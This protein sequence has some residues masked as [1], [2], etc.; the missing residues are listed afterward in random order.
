MP[1]AKVRN[2]DLALMSACDGVITSLGTFGWWAGHFSFQ[3][4]G[5][6]IY[7][8]NTFNVS[9]VRKIGEVAKVDNFFPPEWIG[10]EAPALD[11]Q[12]N[13]VQNI[14]RDVIKNQPG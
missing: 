3:N 7:F 14:K 4:G 9:Q 8:K 13:M 1:Q 2:H 12:G 11:C 5:E 10:I 6:V